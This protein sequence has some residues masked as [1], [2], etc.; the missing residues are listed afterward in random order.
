M[1]RRV[2]PDKFPACR[3]SSISCGRSSPRSATW[4]GRR[5]LL[6]WDEWTKMPP[7]GARARGEQ[8]ATLARIR[9]ERLTSD[10]LGRL[11]DEAAVETD[12]LPYESD[13]A[14]LVRVTRRDW[15]KARR[16]PAELRAEITRNASVAEHA[17]VEARE[18]SDYAAYLPYL[19]RSVELKRRYAEC[20]EGFNGFE[21]VY[22]PL[23]DDFE[24]GMTTA[25][26]SCGARRAPRRRPSA[27]GRDRRS[28]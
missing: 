14:S 23:L 21:H 27:D 24:P 1:G 16:V 19:E 11:V 4:V 13:E 7:G 6:D 26:V 17:W 10:E 15:E 28:R 12:G 18:R 9:H 3:P 8:Q 2:R 5:H 25:E 22:D 20:F